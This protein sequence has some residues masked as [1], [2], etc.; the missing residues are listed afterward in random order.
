MKQYEMGICEFI[1][2]VI[3]SITT[4]KL[5]LGVC[6]FRENRIPELYLV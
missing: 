1:R 6:M 3:N 2:I 4:G 5:I